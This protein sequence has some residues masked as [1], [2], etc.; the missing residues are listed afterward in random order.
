M[1]IVYPPQSEGSESDLFLMRFLKD[2][3]LKVM[4]DHGLLVL[5]T[6][7]ISL[8][9]TD[10][11]LNLV[12]ELQG[13]QINILGPS[14][15][16]LLAHK[17]QPL[18]PLYVVNQGVPRPSDNQIRL[19][20]SPVQPASTMGEIAA[21]R[22]QF[23]IPGLCIETHDGQNYLCLYFVIHQPE[24]TAIFAL[25]RPGQLA[26]THRCLPQRIHTMFPRD[27]V[28][29]RWPHADG[30]SSCDEDDD[31]DLDLGDDDWETFPPSPTPVQAPT[32]ILRSRAVLQSPTAPDVPS[33]PQAIWNEEWTLTTPVLY[34]GYREDSLCLAATSG[35]PPHS[36]IYRGESVAEAA[37]ELFKALGRCVDDGD[38][39]SILS[40]DQSAIIYAHGTQRI[41]SSG[42]GIVREVMHAAFIKTLTTTG[43]Q[44]LTARLDHKLSLLFVRSLGFGP[45]TFGPRQQLISVSGALWALMLI[46]GF[47]VDPIDP[48]LLQFL[49]HDC[50]L[51]SVHPAFLAEYHPDVKHVLDLWKEAGPTGDINLPPIVSHLA[52]YHDLEV[53]ALKSRDQATHD[54]LLVE[55]LYRSVIGS[56]PPSHPDLI[57]LAT[58]FRLP[59]RNGF[60]FTR[61]IR[62]LEGGSDKFLANVMTSVIG[63]LAL[64]SRLTI[65]ATRDLAVPIETAM[66]GESL[67]DIITDYLMGSG[68]PCPQLFEEAQQHFPSVVDLL[69]ADSPNFR[70]QMLAWAVSGAPFLATGSGNI[71]LLLVDDRDPLY[72]GGRGPAAAATF[73]NSGTISFRTC[74]IYLTG[75]SHSVPLYSPLASVP[76]DQWDR[77]PHY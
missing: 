19:R 28:H 42:E 76:I 17:N 4:K 23:A 71:S 64:I 14:H 65:T 58:G 10:H 45:H 18:V 69:L 63:P 55:M 44:W 21:N 47:A 12:Q 26:R 15:T 22:V 11:I 13:R 50:N 59:C 9:V 25:P 62:S 29:E 77:K 3:F 67:A 32:R 38:F 75:A 5:Q 49:I 8:P 56:E 27:R 53:S 16:S 72:L 36:V 33:L 70:S 24:L 7:P 30:E 41:V 48:A 46:K 20:R 2:T 66:G 43:P 60:T 31:T 6:S 73:V 54:G 68:I 61:F 34:E 39:T 52:T 37:D 35:T 74:L 40:D 57:A 1:N 51:H